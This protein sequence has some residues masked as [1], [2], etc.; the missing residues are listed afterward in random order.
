M[1][2]G[3]KFDESSTKVGRR[4]GNGSV[5]TCNVAMVLQH[6]ATMVLLQRNDGGAAALRWCYC[7]TAM[8]ELAAQ[9]W[10]SLLRR[11][12]SCSV[13]MVLLQHSDG[14]ASCATMVELVATLVELT[15]A[16]LQLAATVRNATTLRRYYN[17]QRSDATTLL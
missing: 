7:S 11:W 2:I 17:S 3:R 8:V 10:W 12:W 6:C 13:A 15:T 1:D 14:G 5:A 4:G 16:L 9:Q